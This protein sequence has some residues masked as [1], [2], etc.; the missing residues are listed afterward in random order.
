[1]STFQYMWRMIRYRPWL[2]SAN[3]VIWS[4]VH[5]S[6][7]IPGLIIHEF[8]DMLTGDATLGFGLWELAVLLVATALLRV[9]IIFLGGLLDIPHRFYMS[10]LLRRNMLE[11]ILNRPGARALPDSTGEA[12]NQFRDD[13]GQAE[14]AVDWTLDVIGMS[15]FAIAAIMILT[16]INLKITLLVFAPL[17]L[18]VAIAHMAT[19]KLQQY[20]LESR[21]AT[22]RVSGAVGE[23][24]DAVQAIQVAGA[25]ERIIRQ[26]RN[27][28]DRRREHVLKDRLISLGLESIFSNTVSLGTGLILLLTAGSMQDGHFT[29]GDFAIFVYYLG[30]VTEF[31]QFFGRFLAHFKQTTVSFRRMN[32]LLQDA[33]VEQLV[34]H[35][36]LHMK[37]SL[38]VMSSAVKSEQDRL[39]TLEAKDLK[40]LYPESGRGMDGVSLMLARGTFTVITGRIGSGKTTLLRTLLGLLPMESGEI[41]WNGVRVDDPGS[42][43]IPPRSAYTPQVPRLFSDTLEHN[44]LLGHPGSEQE[45]NEAIQSAVM[46][47]DIVQLEHGLQT[48]IG[49]RGVKLSGGQIQRTAVARMFIRDA[50]LFVFDDVSSALDVRTEQIL[51]ERMAKRSNITCLVVSHRKAALKRADHIIVLKDGRM[52]AEGTLDDLLRTSD[53]MRK[54][55]NE[56][57]IAE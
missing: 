46:E 7:L 27:L 1:M 31:T 44:I 3:A 50:E 26:F 37:D 23:M 52:E 24:F 15:L 4:L 25:E 47:Q 32:E 11:H 40:C 34:H 57:R 19:T 36:Q 53:E 8:F 55:W 30:F 17:A 33:P 22:G 9:I 28:N 21:K 51:W 6:P 45:L 43:F 18:V 10:A 54:L 29:V 35:G 39:H 12:I 2:Y 41:V 42:F 48:M 20:R 13:A 16:T 56:D 38:P 14:D 49:P 5:L